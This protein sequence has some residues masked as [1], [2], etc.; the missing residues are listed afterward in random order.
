MKYIFLIF[1]ISISNVVLADTGLENI[2]KR[3]FSDFRFS[4]EFYKKSQGN[5]NY[6][7]KNG[8]VELEEIKIN[9]VTYDS[10]FKGQ[11]YSCASCHMTDELVIDDKVISRGH[12][13]FSKFTKVPFRSDNQTHTLRNT[14]SLTGVGS[15][16]LQNRFSHYDGELADHSNTV[17]GNFTGRNMGWPSNESRVALNNIVKVIREDNGTLEFSRKHFGSYKK[18]L[19]G[20]DPSIPDDYK[21]EKENR[22][23]VESASSGKIL[24]FVVTAVTAFMNTLDFKKDENGD[25][26]GSSYDQFLKLNN[27]PRS[28]QN[29]ENI[30]RYAGKLR[31]AL[32]NLKDIKFIPGKFE[33]EEWKGLRVF[34]NLNKRHEGGRGMCLPCHVPPMFTDQSFSNIGVS[35]IEYEKVHGE[36]SFKLLDIPTL[37][38]RKDKTFLARAD[39]NDKNKA[40]LGVWNFYKRKDHITRYMNE[41]FCRNPLECNESLVLDNLIANFKTPTLRNL[42]NSA[43]YFH[44][45]SARDV[46]ETLIHYKITAKMA[47]LGKLVNPAHQIRMI[48]LDDNDLIDLRAFLNAL[49]D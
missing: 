15:K 48:R 49:N 24:K 45:G 43:P 23:D 42:K 35:Q 8:S 26:I 14:T 22:I 5:V 7:L 16:W 27:L 19:L 3:L 33:K 31:S 18:L 44:D 41:L 21:L 38:E 6:I 11:T 30:Y 13:D 28:P 39:I 34:F 36:E 20:I 40:D 9:D 25:Y 1:V 47:Q 4:Q 10:P 12:N 46:M 37:N 29:G 2:G 32:L 17:L